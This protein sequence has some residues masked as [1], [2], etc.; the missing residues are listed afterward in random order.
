MSTRQIL[1]QAYFQAEL[2]DSTTD[3]TSGCTS[4]YTSGG[5]CNQ[6]S[7][8]EYLDIKHHRL[9]FYPVT[10]YIYI[11]TECACSMSFDTSQ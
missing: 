5:T 6:V 7:C 11:Y 9:Q 1:S 2:S 3:R 10:L 4:G 8:S